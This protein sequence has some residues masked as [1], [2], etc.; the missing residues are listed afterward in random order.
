MAAPAAAA[1]VA[2]AAA[3]AIMVLRFV[4][5]VDMLHQVQNVF[6]KQSK[7]STTALCHALRT[8]TDCKAISD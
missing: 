4:L 6:C 8:Y 3:A 1:A 2:A 5:L 7:T